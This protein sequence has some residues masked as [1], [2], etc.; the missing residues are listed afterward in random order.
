MAQTI[1]QEL[2]DKLRNIMKRLG[3][4]SERA[5]KGSSDLEEINQVV[6]LQKNYFPALDRAVKEKDSRKLRYL[7]LLLSEDLAK[8]FV[9]NTRKDLDVVKKEVNKNK[10]ETI[11]KFSG[12]VYLAS[13]YG[14]PKEVNWLIKK[15]KYQTKAFIKDIMQA[16]ERKEKIEK[17]RKSVESV[18]ES[19]G[20]DYKFS[21]VVAGAKIV[22]PEDDTNALVASRALIRAAAGE[23]LTGPER[24]ALD[25][26]IELFT[27]II[28]DN[29][30]RA[31]LKDMQ[32]IIDKKSSDAAKEK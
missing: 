7:L 29:S 9:D 26:Y 15:G 5:S 10:A 28:T 20:K 3:D 30:L 24:E 4:P 32:R 22:Q 14:E 1:D 13:K 19:E 21:D 8:T 23:V 25:A 12:I 2:T 16:A 6:G 18:Q 11:I 31:R 17:M 27:T